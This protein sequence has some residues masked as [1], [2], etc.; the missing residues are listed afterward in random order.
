MTLLDLLIAGVIVTLFL[1]PP[2]RDTSDADFINDEDEQPSGTYIADTEVTR[3][4][5]TDVV[6]ESIHGNTTDKSRTSI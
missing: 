2:A 4:D 3:H 6:K 5:T 1:L